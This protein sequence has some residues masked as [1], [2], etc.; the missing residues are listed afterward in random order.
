MVTKWFQA[1]LSFIIIVTSFMSVS[2]ALMQEEPP[3]AA[4]IDL[5]KYISVDGG[6][7]WLDADIL[8]GPQVEEGDPILFRVFVSNTGDAELSNIV[9]TDTQFDTSTCSVPETLAAGAFFD[10]DFGPVDAED[11]EYTNTATITADAETGTVTDS[12]SASYLGEAEEEDEDLEI[13]ITIEGPVEAVIVNVIVI[14]GIEIAL[15]P[16]DPLLTVI[17]IGDIVHVEGA[18]TEADGVTII[19]AVT[20]VIVNVEIYIGGDDGGGIW[21]DDGNCSNPPPSWAPAWGW[22]RKCEGITKPGKK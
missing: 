8:P 3:A 12:D 19:V 16:D 1:L 9:L 14:Y 13:V 2:P 15:D 17:E 20:V 22:R 6:T 18:V 10:C 5:E 21:I 11:G 4:A 7:T